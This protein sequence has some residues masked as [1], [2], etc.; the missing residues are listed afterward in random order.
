MRLICPR[1]SVE[2]EIED[3]LIPAGGREV[4]CSSCD[5]VWFQ[6]GRLRMESPRLAP[7][8]A[9]PPVA[10]AEAAPSLMPKGLP[11]D[12]MDILRD[13]AAH[14][15]ASR[16]GLTDEADDADEPEAAA[17]PVA[18]DDAPP[19]APAKVAPVAVPSTDPPAT[20]KVADA[21]EPEAAPE[22]AP[23]AQ[24]AFRRSE[25][26]ESEAARG[27]GFV[28]GFLIGLVI[29]AGFYA[30]YRLAPD[31]GEGVLGDTLRSLRAAGISAHHWVQ[32]QIAAFR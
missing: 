17:P 12:V 11:E 22:P 4:Q 14:F 8:P 13:E 16:P 27:G 18:E 25:F 10:E 21:A 15:R 32:A 5:N 7:A 23:T 20:E 2:Y 9:D 3:R 28:W 29:A 6:L 26:S 30:N 19:A 24:P 31:M 1:C